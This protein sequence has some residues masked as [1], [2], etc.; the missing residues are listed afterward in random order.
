MFVCLYIC[1]LTARSFTGLYCKWTLRGEPGQR[2]K[3]A[4]LEFD[5]APNDPL[6]NSDGFIV[7][8]PVAKVQIGMTPPSFSYTKSRHLKW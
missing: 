2:L 1:V 4:F 6:C 7:Y 8:D 3:L 5:V